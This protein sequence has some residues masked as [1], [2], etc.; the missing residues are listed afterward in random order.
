MYRDTLGA[1]LYRAGRFDDAAKQLI[2]A[3]ALPPSQQTA[4]A[5]T[6]FFLSVTHHRLGHTDEARRW[7]EKGIQATEE[8]LTAQQQNIINN[9]AGVT[10]QGSGAANSAVINAAANQRVF[11]IGAG[12]NVAFANLTIQGGVATDSG[13]PEE[14]NEARDG[15]ILDQG[16]NVSLNNVVVQSNQALGG[17]GDSAGGGGIYVSGGTL[18]ITGS[19]IRNNTA[20][21]D[22][23]T[24]SEDALGG[25]IDADLPPLKPPGSQITIRISN[26][27]ISGNKAKGVSPGGGGGVAINNAITQ[28]GGV[29]NALI[30]NSSITGNF[31]T[32]GTIVEGGVGSLGGGLFNTQGTVQLINTTVATNKAQGVD[33]PAQG[34]GVYEN[35]TN[36]DMYLRADSASLM[37]DRQR[38]A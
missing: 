14:T 22:L 19:A 29:I 3:S 26:S 15:G 30:L 5:Y 28:Y 1:A 18:T 17:S 7:L 2:K 8:A 34:G 25:G 9:T 35:S 38:I 37:F 11:Q 33:A 4:M 27:T 31:A 6:W 16:G 21:G 24:L 23:S 13:N 20:K 32:G 10:I 12:A 36:S